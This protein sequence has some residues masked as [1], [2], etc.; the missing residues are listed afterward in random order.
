[1]RE[2]SPWLE[3]DIALPT[4]VGRD[5]VADQVDELPRGG[6]YKYAIW[7]YTCKA[8]RL[9]PDGAV[10][11]DPFLWGPCR[12]RARRRR[13]ASTVR[14]T[15]SRT[16]GARARKLT[17]RTADLMDSIKDDRDTW[18]DTARIGRWV[19]I[20]T[21]AVAALAIVYVLVRTA[22]VMDSWA[23]PA[24]IFALAVFAAS[25]AALFL[26]ARPLQD[27]D[28]WTPSGESK[29]KEEE[30]EAEDEETEEDAKDKPEPKQPS[31]K[32]AAKPKGRARG[33]PR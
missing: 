3:L 1:M 8:Y 16:I 29:A 15:R 2:G 11:D 14:A 27:I 23:V 22:D 25:P 9:G 13:S 33:I 30:G 28:T 21:L 12:T 18:R 6:V 19:F 24:I 31:T 10:H 20:G 32:V 5:V 17:T 4:S 7:R 26:L